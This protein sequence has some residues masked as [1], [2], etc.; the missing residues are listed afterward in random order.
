[1]D[2]K[3]VPLSRAMEKI[4]KAQHPLQKQPQEKQGE[5]PAT[6]TSTISPETIM[7]RQQAFEKQ[8]EHADGVWD[9][10]RNADL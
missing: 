6:V 7:A 10:L 2:A 3:T 5:T 9:P 1:M 4:L 8:E